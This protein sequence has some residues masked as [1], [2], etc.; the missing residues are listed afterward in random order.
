MK[1]QAYKTAINDFKSL[2]YQKGYRGRFSLDRGH[3]M[4]FGALTDCLE[5]FVRTLTAEAIQAPLKLETYAAYKH[6]SDHIQCT[7]YGKLDTVKGFVIEQMD[8]VQRP[9]GKGQSYRFTNNQQIPGINAVIGLFPKPKP[10]DHLLK[11]K[12]RP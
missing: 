10:W 2:M 1:E 7:L 5:T 12:F 11:G 9:S 4:D 6:A 3:M 8:V